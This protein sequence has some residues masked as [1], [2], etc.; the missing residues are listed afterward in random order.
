MGFEKCCEGI[1]EYAAQLI[2]NKARQLV[3]HV[4]FTESDR[5]DL[6]QEMM[7][8]LLVRLPK[9]DPS[10]AASTTFVAMVVDRKISKIIRHR[11]Q[12]KRD[13]RRIVSSCNDPIEDRDGT[14]IEREQTIS[15]DEIDLQTGKH[16]R[17][18]AERIDMRLDVSFAISELPPELQ[19]LARRLMDQSIAEAARELGVP[20]STLYETGIARLR[21]FFED[22]GLSEYL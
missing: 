14:T 17:P 8:D 15:K 1:N 9:F 5:E 6:E 10:K 12:E 11:T 3:G 18:E 16:A 13:Y 19:A 2:K 7:L 21:N 4:G 20:R 22:R